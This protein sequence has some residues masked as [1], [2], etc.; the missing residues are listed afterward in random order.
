MIEI[1]IWSF[2]QDGHKPSPFYIVTNDDNGN[3]SFVPF[4]ECDES[5]YAEVTE[6]LES[7]SRKSY[8]KALC[9]IA[10]MELS[11]SIDWKP[12]GRYVKQIRVRQ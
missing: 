3:S 5:I 7:K 11:A 9:K 6:I 2:V 10:K 1:N 12:Y 8:Y 4:D